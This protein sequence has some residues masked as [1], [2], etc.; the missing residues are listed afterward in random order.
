MDD[1]YLALIPENCRSLYMALRRFIW[2]SRTKGNKLSREGFKRG[3]LVAHIGQDTLGEYL[4]IS[5]R[6]VRSRLAILLDMGAIVACDIPRGG[7][8]SFYY[9][10]GEYIMKGS[11]GGKRVEILYLELPF[12][13]AHIDYVERM[14]EVLQS[15][16]LEEPT[17]LERQHVTQERLEAYKAR[18]AAHR[19]IYGG[20]PLERRVLDTIERWEE[21]GLDSPLRR[22]IPYGVRP[23]ASQGVLWPDEMGAQTVSSGTTT[24]GSSGDAEKGSET[25][26]PKNA[27]LRDSG[28]GSNPAICSGSASEPEALD[29]IPKSVED[30]KVT[31]A[32]TREE[33]VEK[34]PQKKIREKRL[35][36]SS[37]RSEEVRQKRKEIAPGGA[38]PVLRDQAS[39]VEADPGTLERKDRENRKDRT[40]P[41][42]PT[43]LPAEEPKPATSGMSFREM[44]AAEPHKAL[45]GESA[46]EP[47]NSLR[48]RK[49]APKPTTRRSRTDARMERA[50]LER[51]AMT[52]GALILGNEITP[53]QIA[54][55]TKRP[56]QKMT[57]KPTSVSQQLWGSLQRIHRTWCAVMEEAF[58]GS[59]PASWVGKEAGLART[60]I[61]LYGEQDFHA[62]IRYV[63]PNYERLIE[64]R[65]K[66]W[67]GFPTLVFLNEWHSTFFA[68]G[69]I[70]AEI[71]ADVD[72]Y[73]AW[74]S[75]TT[76]RWRKPDNIRDLV[77][78]VNP[79]LVKMGLEPLT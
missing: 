72:A 15:K 23:D 55:G 27:D 8:R 30:P 40:E 31:E 58:P 59:D 42:P 74:R 19:K 50:T 3:L 53:E 37:L 1:G 57:R 33:A 51:D 17:Y 76:S 6:T 52:D 35:T 41:L 2:R 38:T 13:E 29:E 61:G 44:V 69:R 48:G 5:D 10:L 62:A 56:K 79:K 66:Q 36:S 71:Q 20:F 9:L 70:Y 12:H 32:G 21:E 11:H 65:Y 46:Q 45:E 75:T 77:E 24:S 54:E 47:S 68:E 18:H 78:R 39:Q 26:P 28:G 63:I 14:R 73:T 43:P 22:L 4:G 64:T 60:L 67:V 49:P 7:D 16:D 25:P 34:V